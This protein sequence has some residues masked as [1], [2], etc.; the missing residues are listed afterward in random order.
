[1]IIHEHNK[2]PYV[3]QKT[4]Y[5]L[6][7]YYYE[8]VPQYEIEKHGFKL[9]ENEKLLKNTEF[10]EEP[11]YALLKDG[12]IVMQ[13]SEWILLKTFF[14]GRVTVGDMFLNEIERYYNHV[15]N[16]EAFN[17]RDTKDKAIV[18]LYNELKDPEKWLYR[19]E[20]CVYHTPKMSSLDINMLKWI[21]EALSNFLYIERK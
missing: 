15:V 4:I 6:N 1:M 5:Q 11:Y 8:E 16:H 3:E 7:C 19:F 9:Y 17:S 18:E 14:D 13:T 21:G 10:I 2:K 12:E 20:H